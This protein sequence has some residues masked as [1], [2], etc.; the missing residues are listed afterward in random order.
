VTTK[1][2][3]LEICY[4]NYFYNRMNYSILKRIIWEI[5]KIISSLLLGSMY[6]TLSSIKVKQK[7]LVSKTPSAFHISF[8]LALENTLTFQS[9]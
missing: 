3:G 5:F 1:L 4:L 2:Q 7:I 6:F 8:I 9:L